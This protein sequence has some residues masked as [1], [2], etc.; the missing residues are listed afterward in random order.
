[1][2]Q[3]STE[4]ALLSQATISSQVQAF[5]TIVKWE[6]KTT[7]HTRGG[8]HNLWHRISFLREAPEIKLQSLLFSNTE[9]LKMGKD[10]F[11]LFSH[12]H[13]YFKPLIEKLWPGC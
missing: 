11:Y 1:M 4:T 8:I 2:F 13:T 6:G 5:L 10:T 9:I 12:F 3:C 7:C